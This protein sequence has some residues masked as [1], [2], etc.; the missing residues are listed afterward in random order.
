[1]SQCISDNLKLENRLQTKKHYEIKV[2]A[3]LSI[4]R[5]EFC[6]PHFHGFVNIGAFDLHDFLCIKQCRV[7]QDGFYGFCENLLVISTFGGRCV[8]DVIKTFIK[9]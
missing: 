9:C 1:M 3:L 2:F 5:F 7:V 4:F 8:S 6:V